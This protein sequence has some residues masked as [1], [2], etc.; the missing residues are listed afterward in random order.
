MSTRSN[1]LIKS[2]DTNIW[3]YRHMDGHLSET[4]YNL[5]VTLAHS[6]SY[7]NFMNQLLSYKYDLSIYSS[8]RKAE[9]IYEMT[10]GQ[11]GDIEDLYTFEFDRS[12]PHFVKVQIFSIGWGENKDNCLID[13]EFSINNENVQKHLKL[14]FDERNKVEKMHIA[15]DKKLMEEG[16]TV[17]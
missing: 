11:H 16:Y 10:T 6:K 8:Y 17:N 1:V 5:A 14:I 13:T 12:M 3:I 9:P 15:F 4:G 2:G 7:Q